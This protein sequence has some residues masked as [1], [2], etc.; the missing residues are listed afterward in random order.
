MKGIEEVQDGLKV[1][2]GDKGVGV[3][4]LGDELFNTQLQFE[5][6]M[7][8]RELEMGEINRH[9]QILV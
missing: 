6:K 3:K 5:E 8:V 4:R 7:R 2:V 1:E 9:I